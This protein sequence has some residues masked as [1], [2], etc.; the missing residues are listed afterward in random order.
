MASFSVSSVLF[1]GTNERDYKETKQGTFV[2]KGDGVNFYE[3]EF[4]TKLRVAG[5]T[6]EHYTDAVSKIVDGLR[7]DAF[8]VAQEV[9]LE[10]LYEA[11][12]VQKLCAAM[13]E[14]VFPLT[15]QEAKELFRQY[16]KPAGLLSRQKSESMRQYI[17][18]RVRCWKLLKELDPQIEL[19]E[20]HRADM[21]L[22]SAGLDK[23]ERT[24]IQASIRNARNFNKIAEALIAQ[25][26]RVHVSERGRATPQ[27]RG[28]GGGG[29]WKRP[30]GKG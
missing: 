30:K 1:S 8:V 13:K 26:P 15:E 9:G 2:Y 22:E 29:G 7:G 24:M 11:D 23:N 4:R 28:K 19:S 17:S 12:G 3:W 14:M 21:L 10:A 5:K 20:G 25:H 27:G 16:T 6:G 18:R